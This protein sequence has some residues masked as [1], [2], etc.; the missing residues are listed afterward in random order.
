MAVRYESTAQTAVQKMLPLQ[1]AGGTTINQYVSGGVID[2]GT[3]STVFGS[4]DPIIDA[5]GP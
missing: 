5:G 3:P 1:A 2:G 4:G